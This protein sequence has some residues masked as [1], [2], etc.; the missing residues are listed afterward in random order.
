MNHSIDIKKLIQCYKS[1]MEYSVDKPPTQKQFLT[2]MEE[3]MTDKEFLDDI[4]I[5]LKQGVEYDNERAWEVVKKDLI[6]KIN[7]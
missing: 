1:Y 7:G 6:E 5:I 4:Y 2:N 3:K